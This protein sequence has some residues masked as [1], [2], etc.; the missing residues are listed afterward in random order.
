LSLPE[1]DICNR[2][3]VFLFHG[4]TWA[5]KHLPDQLWRD[6]SDLINKAGFN[7]KVCWGNPIE[8][9]RAHWI[10]RGREF[11]E[12]LPKSSLTSIALQLK[13]ARG[14][15]AVDTGLGHLSAALAVPSVSI[16][17]ATDPLLTGSFG[18]NQ[19]HL[20]SGLSCSPC[21]S[22]TCRKLNDDVLLPP[23]YDGFSASNI[24]NK[25]SQQF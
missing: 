22:K 1:S 17:G 21:L 4:T 20:Q 2:D 16:Y 3:S 8:E 18:I 13:T 23:C 11:V 19:A 7:V 10:S 15:I 14:V 9:K 5:T 12:V 6:L 25:L 24:W